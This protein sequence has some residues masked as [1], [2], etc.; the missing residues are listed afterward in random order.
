MKQ[1]I[2]QAEQRAASIGTRLDTGHL[3]LALVA[4]KGTAANLLRL[5]GL[6]E[7]RVRTRLNGLE[8][9]RPGLAEEAV[10]KAGQIA[11]PLQTQ[12]PSPL[13]LLAAVSGLKGS[14]A[15]RMLRGFGLDP[16][17]IRTGALRCLTGVT[18]D[19]IIASGR[20]VS[21]PSRPGGELRP[22]R[23]LRKLAGA[24]P[25]EPRASRNLRTA[26]PPPANLPGEARARDPLA[27]GFGARQLFEAGADL[28]RK[29]RETRAKQGLPPLDGPLCVARAES[30]LDAAREITREPTAA[31]RE[32]ALRAVSD[33]P[34]DSGV[35]VKEFPLLAASGRNVTAAARD[36]DLDPVVGRIAEMERIA[37]VLNK[38][39]ANCPC[40]V[41]PS[42]VG[43]TAIVEG[44]AARLAEGRAPELGDREIIEIGPADLVGGT[45]V[46]GALSERLASLQDEMN[47][48]A[49]RIVLFFD[50]LGALLSSSDGADA[51]SE[52]KDALSRGEL[53]CIATTTDEEFA[54]HIET[55]PAL[56]RVF[57]PIEIAEPSIAETVDI[58]EGVTPAYERHHGVSYS[59][60]ALGAAVR[61]SSRYLMDR[62]LPDKAIALLDMSGA[63]ARRADIERVEGDDVARV[64]AD[65]INVPFES[66]AA[67]ETERLLHVEEALS[68][69]IVGHRHV[70]SALGETLRRNAA[71]FR[72]G[73]PIGS[74]LFL[75]PTG[76]GKT[77]TAKALGEFLFAGTS[78]LVRLD[79]S[80]FAEAH[81]L[82]R[83]IGAP[84]GY[85]GHEEGGQLT[86]A[87]RRRPY[88]LVL[89]D[90][91]EKAS[92]E[93]L[94]VLLQVLDDGRLTDGLGRTVIFENTVVVMTSNLGSNLRIGRRQV[95]FGAAREIEEMGDIGPAVLGA[96]RASLPP[97]L[98][99]RID[100]PLV[101]DPLTREDVRDIA[102]MMLK[103][104]S[105][106]LRDEQGV[107][108]SFDD[109][110]VET[111]IA[112]G[113]YDPD[114][115]A[116][117]MR[118]TVQRLVEGPVARIVL[119]G[120]VVRGGRIELS[121]D[122]ESIE[123]RLA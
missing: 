17:A 38:R 11:A 48:A 4:G 52:L 49:G 84:P 32:P 56:A 102:A 1:I 89:L 83:L 90:E 79:M 119:S 25:N 99:N 104:I 112:Q 40:L 98:W 86:E 115:G 8:E 92:P 105:E 3:L 107:S 44:L 39:R 120:D 121:G 33:E 61:L 57:T 20:A 46:R 35:D 106:Q 13:H 82:A 103:R 64:V 7:E 53:P 58:L 14:R 12:T 77:E 29:Q 18:E 111:L 123:C 101:F 6:T 51:L 54:R 28:E 122:G 10:S 85:V 69:H 95:G 34:A 66:I 67:S 65:R 59:D 75:G 19:H 117:P 72:S 15:V 2:A 91:I 80:E 60:E 63:R 109:D 93:V 74:F 36:G 100:E 23:Q 41:G 22:V 24:T 88:S 96:A 68:R 73:R 47:R 62:A 113:G 42:G 110:V 30:L 76:V 70:L 55:D 26:T 114:L 16:M 43:K 45:S 78:A 31:P 81:A 21:T 108:L 71:G 5:R 87:V 94:K 50:D 37:D 97:E 9:E 116:R 27:P 118:R